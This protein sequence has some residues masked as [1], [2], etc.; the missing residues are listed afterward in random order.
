LYV[1][2]ILEEAR[3]LWSF[4]IHPGEAYSAGTMVDDPGQHLKYRNTAQVGIMAMR[5]LNIDMS[6][7]PRTQLTPQMLNKFDK[8]IVLA[9]PESIPYYLYSAPNVEIYEVE[10]TRY[11]TLEE[12]WAICQQIWKI[13]QNVSLSLHPADKKVS[14]LLVARR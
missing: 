6:E 8:V 11:K 14:R 1:V 10:D 12:A 2:Q 9:E 5:R 7:N 13:V 3:L 4:I